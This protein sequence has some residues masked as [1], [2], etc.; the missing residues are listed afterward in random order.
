M[1]DGVSPPRNVT[2]T[3]GSIT[4]EGYLDALTEL[5]DLCLGMDERLARTEQTLQRIE[6]LTT[7]RIL[8]DPYMRLE[9]RVDAIDKT[10]HELG[11]SVEKGFDRTEVALRRTESLGTD[12]TL[13]QLAASIDTR[14]ADTTETVTRIE[15]LVGSASLRELSAAVNA[16]LMQ[17]E[18]TLRQ[19]ERA[20][21][22][23]RSGRVDEANQRGSSDEPDVRRE[24]AQGWMATSRAMRAAQQRVANLWAAATAGRQPYEDTAWAATMTRVNASRLARRFAA[25]LLLAS[26]LAVVT[27]RF[28]DPRLGFQDGRVN[29]LGDVIASGKMTAAATP[30]IVVPGGEAVPV[31]ASTIRATESGPRTVVVAPP[32][33]QVVIPNAL[34]QTAADD[35]AAA[36]SAVPTQFVGALEITSTPAGASVFGNGRALGVTPLRIS[37]QRAGSLA[38]Q[39]TR[40]GYQRWSASIQVRADSLTQVAAT[41]RPAEF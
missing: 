7:D 3:K 14:L 30:D 35:V 4:P 27:V 9:E 19:I 36:E 13:R 16:R 18:E 38:L 11:A 1:T 32:S 5:Y 25:V 26:V 31:L 8:L 37:K 20:L 10:V 12:R 34:G 17:T 15:R 2:D 22:T 39:I 6:D 41:L 23:R 21:D 24:L 29:S 40:E 28:N 33:P